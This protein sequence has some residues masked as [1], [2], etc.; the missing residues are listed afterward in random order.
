MEEGTIV[1]WNV[2]PGEALEEDTVIGQVETDKITVDFVSPVKGILC[3]HL[4]EPGTTVAV[5]EDIVVIAD[6]QQDYEAY[7]ASRG[8]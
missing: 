1:E 4:V 7:L 5:G 3:A 2:Q 6:D 8:D